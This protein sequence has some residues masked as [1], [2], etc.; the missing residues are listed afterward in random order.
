MKNKNDKIRTLN[1][2]VDSINVNVLTNIVTSFISKKLNLD[3]NSSMAISIFLSSI[4]ASSLWSEIMTIEWGTIF[5]SLSQ[6]GISFLLKTGI[7]MSILSGLYYAY[8]RK[9]KDKV[10]VSYN[11][12]VY[13][14]NENMRWI[15]SFIKSYTH[16]FKSEIDWE[17]QNP[18]YSESNCGESIPVIGNKMYFND[19]EQQTRGYIY[20]GEFIFQKNV[21]NRDGTISKCDSIKLFA[22]IH[23]DTESKLSAREYMVHIIKLYA[24]ANHTLSLDYD[25][26]FPRQKNVTT[27]YYCGKS[28]SRDKLYEQWMKTFFSPHKTY[29]WNYISAIHYEPEIFHAKGQGAYCNLILYGPPGTGKSSFAYRIAR[30]LERSIY[31]V[32][33]SSICDDKSKVYHAIRSGFKHKQ[34]KNCS[35]TVI[36]IKCDAC[37]NKNKNISSASAVVLLEEFDITFRYLIN[38]QKKKEEKYR[39]CLE[40]GEPFEDEKTRSEDFEI[41][42]LLEILQ[43]PVPNEGGI[44]IATTN[45]FEEMKEQCPALFRPG[46]LTPV[47]FDYLDYGSLQELTEYYFGRK[48][49]FP[50]Q[51]KINVPT[52][53]IIEMAMSAN[54]THKKDSDEAFEYFKNALNNRLSL[55]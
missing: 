15:S 41:Q 18:K 38:K 24:A 53:E 2:S 7:V 19:E 25:K 5:L 6:H 46:R 16:L 9:R 55:E 13:H 10:T 8:K 27:T 48:L 23:I 21:Q 20:F 50:S 37:K 4:L 44:I 35:C 11:K 1:M 28:Q 14:N 47:H 22:S 52:S 51:I 36:G 43:G 33:I 29:L 17:F 54:I 26:M 34:N 40:K 49:E 39:A 32:D 30:C 31:S 3:L 45:H 42:D 12:V